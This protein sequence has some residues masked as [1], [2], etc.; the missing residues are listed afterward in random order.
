[1]G[2]AAL[3]GSSPLRPHCAEY[4]IGTRKELEGDSDVKLFYLQADGM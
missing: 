4:G 3:G 2:A 1:M